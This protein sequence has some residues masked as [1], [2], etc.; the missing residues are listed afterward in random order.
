MFDR[1]LVAISLDPAEDEEPVYCTYNLDGE[2][3]KVRDVSKKYESITIEDA[4]KSYFQLDLPYIVYHDAN[5][6]ELLDDECEVL[7]TRIFK[8]EDGVLERDTV[9]GNDIGYKS[10]KERVEKINGLF[11]LPG[12]PDLIYENYPFFRPDVEQSHEFSNEEYLTKFV[13]KFFKSI[14][15]KK[16]VF[17]E[18]RTNSNSFSFAINDLMS[19]Q[20]PVEYQNYFTLHPGEFFDVFNDRLLQLIQQ[21]YSEIIFKDPKAQLQNYFS[22]SDPSYNPV[23]NKNDNVS[24]KPIGSVAQSPYAFGVSDGDTDLLNALLVHVELVNLSLG[25]GEGYELYFKTNKKNFKNHKLL[26]PDSTKINNFLKYFTKCVAICLNS[27]TNRF[28]ITD[29]YWVSVFEIEDIEDGE[30]EDVKK[31]VSKVKVRHFSFSNFEDVDDPELSSNLTIRSIIASF[32]NISPSMYKGT[33]KVMG[34]LNEKIIKD[35]ESFKKTESNSVHVVSKINNKKRLKI[36]PFIYTTPSGFRFQKQRVDLEKSLIKFIAIGY[37]WSCQTLSVDIKKLFMDKLYYSQLNFDHS[38]SNNDNRKSKKKQNGQAKE[39]LL[40][41]YDQQYDN[42]QFDFGQYYREESKPAKSYFDPGFEALNNQ[43]E[44]VDQFYARWSSN[45]EVYEKLAKL[46][47]DVIAK[48]IDYGYL[49][50]KA[51]NGEELHFKTDGYYII[52]E[53]ISHNF[54]DMTLIDP[55]KEEHYRLTKETM[56]KIHELGVSMNSGSKLTSDVLRYYKG[57][58]YVINLEEANTMATKSTKHRDMVDIDKIFNRTVG[59][60]GKDRSKKPRRGSQSRRGHKNH[61]HNHLHHHN[62]RF[63]LLIDSEEDEGVDYGGSWSMDESG[64]EEVED[65]LY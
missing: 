1:K 32:F 38:A 48:V 52:Y 62:H 50:D 40:S 23:L 36:A 56:T 45:V 53:P 47:G 64:D 57:K 63:N 12:K 18:L 22:D 13:S 31:L 24:L 43:G 19:Y 49:E 20:T 14:I 28:I 10:K 16:N 26:G 21:I 4:I 61:H 25:I 27:K 39:V 55:T 60:D 29:Y 8:A 7:H 30:I 34:S 54:H 9:I 51:H 59:Y 41:I 46:Q 11:N 15:K 33:S 37:D 3:H 17:K 2:F 65:S 42:L 44:T 6:F 5:P 35:W 58:V